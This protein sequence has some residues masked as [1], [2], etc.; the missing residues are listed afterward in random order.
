MNKMLLFAK[1]V[2]LT[3]GMGLTS[4]L[5]FLLAKTTAQGA[6]TAGL[7]A[8]KEAITTIRPWFEFLET[9]R[10]FHTLMILVWIILGGI[11]G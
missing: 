6:A 3:Y 2:L 10:A 9:M 4:I 8:I 5:A 7:L 11:L 1:E